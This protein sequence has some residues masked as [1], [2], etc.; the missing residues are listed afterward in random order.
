VHW[1][2]VIAALMETMRRGSDGWCLIL[3]IEAN[4]GIAWFGQ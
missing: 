2:G 4:E 3:C 1:D